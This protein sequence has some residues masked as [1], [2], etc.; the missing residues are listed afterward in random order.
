MKLIPLTQGQFA[1]VDDEDYEV[2][3]AFKW[4][5][6]RFHGK[7][8]YYAARG[9]VLKT[10]EPRILYMHKALIKSALKI[11]HHDGNGLNNQRVNLRKST[12]TQNCYNAS[13][14]KDNT[15]SV[16]GASWHKREKMWRADITINGKRMWLG[17]F[18]TKEEAAEVYKQASLKYHG[19]FSIF[20]R[21]QLS[22]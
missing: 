18:N 11:D 13:K 5:A 6:V 19:E 8:T 16:K 12:N 4:Y 3:N 22:S 21:P 7:G 20:N 14:R 2:L 10:G 1:M 9:I 15:S 17:Y